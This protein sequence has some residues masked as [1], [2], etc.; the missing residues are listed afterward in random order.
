[1]TIF[2]ETLTA[3]SFRSLLVETQFVCLFKYPLPSSAIRPSN[4]GQSLQ[5]RHSNS[6]ISLCSPLCERFLKFS[7]GNSLF[8][9][10]KHST[11]PQSISCSNCSNL[12]FYEFWPPVLDDTSIL[13]F[14]KRFQWLMF[15][16]FT[17]LAEH[18]KDFRNIK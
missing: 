1:M 9:I 10:S 12:S 15:K 5:I 13:M 2:R 8:S 6:Y 3:P 11:L 4:T 14:I 17:I 18:F 16:L 7:F